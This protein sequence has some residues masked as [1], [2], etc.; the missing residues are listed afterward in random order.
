MQPNTPDVFISFFDSDKIVLLLQ[1]DVA[2]FGGMCMFVFAHSWL[3]F[4]Y[5]DPQRY[6]R[7]FWASAQ[8]QLLHSS[9]QPQRLFCPCAPSGESEAADC[10]TGQHKLQNTDKKQHLDYLY[11]AEKRKLIYSSWQSQINFY[12]MNRDPKILLTSEAG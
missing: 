6:H 4:T 2:F 7:D 1:P 10:S 5:H 12:Y 11:S 9:P 8:T 3:T